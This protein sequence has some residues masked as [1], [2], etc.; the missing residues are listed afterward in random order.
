[1]NDN[2]EHISDRE[3]AGDVQPCCGGGDCCSSGSESG[4]KSWKTLICI[5]VLLAAGAVL[6]HSFIEKSDTDGDQSKQGFA[7]IPMDNMSDTPSPP[8][9]AVKAEIPVETDSR[10]ETPPVADETIKQT[11]PAKAAPSLW[12]AE[13]DSMASLNKMATNTDA[14]FI[15]LTAKGPQDDQTITK[16]IDAAAKKIQAN[17]VRVSAFRL[18]QAAP[19]YAQLAKQVSVPCVLAMV[20]GGGMSAVSGEI[21]E[22][23][24][25]QAF[26]A[27]SRPSSGCCPPGSGVT[28]PPQK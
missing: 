27:A 19:E 6:A 12:K 4:G 26:V 21:S 10:I 3:M 11:I 16:E 15:L 25:V 17:G 9:D 7:P 2:E 23:K 24:L 18:S 1:M 20:K 13:L 8:S 5:L 14:V 22:A 28:C